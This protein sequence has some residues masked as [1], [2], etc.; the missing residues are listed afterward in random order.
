M[1]NGSSVV[2]W[3]RKSAQIGRSGTTCALI[4][5]KMMRRSVRLFECDNSAN[6]IIRCKYRKINVVSEI[7]IS[8]EISNTEDHNTFFQ[9]GEDVRQSARGLLRFHP[10][11]LQE[12][13]LQNG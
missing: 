4:K 10:I 5:G 11:H 12:M 8:L 2:F 1:I 6:V 9:L 7:T 13:D 3:S